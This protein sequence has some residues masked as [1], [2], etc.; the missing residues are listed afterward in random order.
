MRAGSVSV[1]EFWKPWEGSHEN[2]DSERSGLRPIEPSKK[3]KACI[4]NADILK[5]SPSMMSRMP[6]TGSKKLYYKGAAL[7]VPNLRASTERTDPV[8]AETGLVA[9][10]AP[11]QVNL[12]SLASA[13]G[14]PADVARASPLVSAAKAA[15]VRTAKLAERTNIRRT[16]CT[17]IARVEVLASRL[18]SA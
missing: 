2:S 9:A 8:A 4:A 1:N 10:A 5:S 12:G 18:R 11:L 16:D 6:I 14:K 17:S 3:H 15:C 7:P 13:D